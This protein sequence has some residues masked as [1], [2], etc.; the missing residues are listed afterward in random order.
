MKNEMTGFNPTYAKAQIEDMNASISLIQRNF[1]ENTSLFLKKLSE[2]WFSSNAVEFSDLL[3]KKV[4][5]LDHEL[6][7]L[8][9]S[10]VDDSC[11]AYN[12]IAT[13]QGVGTVYVNSG[14]F[15][16]GDYTR[17]SE[18]NANG[19][20]G[21]MVQKVR[22][23]ATEY[24]S[25]LEKVKED[26]GNLPRRIDFYDKAG[27]IAEAINNRI[28]RINQMVDDSIKTLSTELLTALDEEVSLQ[29]SAVSDAQDIMS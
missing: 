26:L 7:Y 24:V 18:A 14:P 12:E 15:V 4:E 21:I 3:V 5:D 17:L 9:E 6:V 25:S 19:D 1:V 13:A 16:G 2:S 23:L 11:S 22:D 8:A 29:E 10:F 27:I 28:N 20:V